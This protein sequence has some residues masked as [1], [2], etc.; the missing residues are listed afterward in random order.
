MITK[1]D[2]EH[3]AKLAQLKL[4]EEEKEMFTRQLGD[5]LAFV[6]KLGELNTEKVEPTFSVLPLSNVTRED[7]AKAS[8]SNDEALSNA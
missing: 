1:K 2:V 5:I 3:A 7:E 8:L 4:T 6:E